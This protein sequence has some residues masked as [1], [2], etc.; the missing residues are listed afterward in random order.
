MLV[1]G[2]EDPAGAEMSQDWPKGPTYWM[3]DDTGYISVPFT[4]NIQDVV[5]ETNSNLFVRK[6]IIGGPAAILMK[7]RLLK[8]PRV[9]VL[10]NM[11]GVLQ[12]VNSQATRTTIGCPN[13]C[14]FCAVPKTEGCL[15]EL[16]DWP[17]LPVLC[18]NNLFAAS[19]SH[20]DKV[21]DR[22]EKLRGVDFNQGVDY[23][24]INGHIIDRIKRL[25]SPIV[26]LACDGEK[27]KDG[28]LEA[29]ECM[30]GKGIPKSWFRSYILVGFDSGFDECWERC[31]FVES[32]GVLPLPQWF[33]ELDSLKPNIITEKQEALGWTERERTGLMG[34]FYQRREMAPRRIHGEE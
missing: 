24:R 22:L 33:H 10:D 7:G 17:D 19:A 13:G 30:R 26:R 29:L 28:W 14:K 6:W 27:S 21:F 9:T 32:H 4:W 5:D 8:N 12:R 20:I 25:K 15:V 11:D 31:K 2:Q 16:E 34:Y 3:D 23:R 18:D 1:L